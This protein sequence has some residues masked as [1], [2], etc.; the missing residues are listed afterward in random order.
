MKRA[1]FV[2]ENIKCITYACENPKYFLIQAVDENDIEVLDKQMEL[3]QKETKEAVFMLAFKV[4]NWNNDLSP[5]TMSAIFGKEDFGGRGECTLRFVENTLLSHVFDSYKLDSTTK[6]ILGGY[7]LAGLFALWAGYN[8]DKFDAIVAASPSVWFKDWA[9]FVQEV[10]PKTSSI[11][12]S[13]GDKE[14]KTRNKTMASVGNVIRIQEEVLKKH[15]INSILEWN[16]GGHFQD[17]EVRLVKGFAWAIE[18][19]K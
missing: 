5:W 4:N 1:E 10:R 2:I 15:G 3:L 13:L 19:I 12:L 7:S 11:Y 16:R 9:E 18:N 17:S 14:E 8:T 6:I